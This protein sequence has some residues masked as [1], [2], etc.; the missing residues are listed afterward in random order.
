MNTGVAFVARNARHPVAALAAWVEVAEKTTAVVVRRIQA[1]ESVR[2]QPFRFS[3]TT[4]PNH[5][6]RCR[7]HCWCSCRRVIRH[8]RPLRRKK[9]PD[10]EDAV[11]RVVSLRVIRTAARYRGDRP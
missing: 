10:D 1:V 5:A 3:G 9:T 7:L 2:A 8:D 11:T 4:Q 6:N